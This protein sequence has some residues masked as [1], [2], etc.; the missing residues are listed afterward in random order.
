MTPN[1][2]IRTDVCVIGGGAAGIS[3]ASQLVETLLKVLLLKSGGMTSEAATQSL[4][5]AENVGINYVPLEVARSRFLSGS[6]KNNAAP[7][8]RSTSKR[9]CMSGSGWVLGTGELR[10][11]YEHAYELL[12]L[13][14]YEYSP[15]RWQNELAPQCVS[16]FPIDGDGV[17]SDYPTITLVALALRLSLM[18]KEVLRPA[19]IGLDSTAPQTK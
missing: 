13:G 4:H 15:V 11:H 16:I 10:P 5:A 1:S 3:I 12:D 17:V 8:I 19:Q 14:P 6:T 9:A 7:W 2:G 18:L